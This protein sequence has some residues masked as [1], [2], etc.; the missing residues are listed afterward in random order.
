MAAAA[1]RYDLTLEELGCYDGQDASKPAVLLAIRG[2]IFDV[3]S[4]PDMYGPEGTY[5]FA[6]DDSNQRACAA[7]RR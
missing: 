6:G 3:S 2:T 7:L 4:R 1:G 5:P